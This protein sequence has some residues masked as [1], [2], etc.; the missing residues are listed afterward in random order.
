MAGRCVYYDV[1]MVSYNNTREACVCVCLEFKMRSISQYNTYI[2]QYII[3]I[4]DGCNLYLYLFIYT[5]GGDLSDERARAIVD[6]IFFYRI[7]LLSVMRI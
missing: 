6:G 1:I 7:Q 3:H 4:Y 2:L 5:Y